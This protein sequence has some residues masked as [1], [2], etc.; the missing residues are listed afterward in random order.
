MAASC[1]IVYT[2]PAELRD[3]LQS[4]LGTF[5]LFN[6][7]GPG[8]SIVSSRWIADAAM[9]VHQQYQPTLELVYLPAPGLRAAEAR[10]RPCRAFTQK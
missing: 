6:F 3:M 1:R 10:A 9:I 7:W 8:S 2:E 5:P 4:Q